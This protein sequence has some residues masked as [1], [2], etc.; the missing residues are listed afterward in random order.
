MFEAVL[1]ALDISGKATTL[2]VPKVTTVNNRTAMIRVG[3]DFRYFDQFD[4][5]SVPSAVS[6]SGSQV[7]SS[8]LVP[9]GAPKLEELGIELSVMPSVGNDLSSIDLNL[10][11]SIS[12]FV[13]YETYQ[14][15]SGTG[16]SGNNNT[17]TN[18]TSLVKIPIFRKSSIETEVIVQSGETVVMGGL[19]SS[20]ETKQVRSVPILSSLPLIGRLFRR[21]DIQDIKQNLLIFVTAT[22]LSER[23][24]DLVPVLPPKADSTPGNPAAQ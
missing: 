17:A 23:G 4:V 1:H 15:G 13:R 24:E 11:P 21:D 10:S 16:S 19:I 8:I 22:L 18:G 20:S 7:Y 12:E 9:V 2:S 6:G 3:E 14:V 5:Q